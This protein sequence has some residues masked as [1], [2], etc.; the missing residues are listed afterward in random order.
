M[1]VYISPSTLWQPAFFGL[2]YPYFLFANIVFILLWLF[3][4]PAYSL[5]PLAVIF[6]GYSHTNN[7]FQFSQQETEEPGLDIV[8]YN[9]QS[10]FGASAKS[11]KERVQTVVNY[12][13]NENNDIVCLQEASYAGRTY[14][15]WETEFKGSN[16]PKYGITKGGQVIMSNYPIINSQKQKFEGTGN[17]FIYADI[18]IHDDTLRI[19]NCHLQ[20]YSFSS[21][22]ISLLDSLNIEN[23]EALIKDAKL[24]TTKIRKGFE[25]RAEQAN[26]LRQSIDESPYPVIVCGD[27]NDTPVSYTYH[28]VVGDDLSD[29][30][31]KAGSGL[32]STYNGKLPSFRIDYIFYDSTFNSFNFETNKK[33]ELSDHYPIKC[34]LIKVISD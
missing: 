7:Y 16:L 26:I 15:E 9:V 3:L 10:F 1:S 25:K 11:V 30:F 20:S 18:V 6:L 27:F 2:A 4:K 29:A 28:T 21:N 33:V 5:I 22:D 23:R 19:Y 24:Y 12:L 17:N 8:S 13:E 32:G 34:R 14:E 31:T